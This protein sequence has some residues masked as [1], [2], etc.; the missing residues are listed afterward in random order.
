VRVA[1]AGHREAVIQLPETLRP[2]LG[3]SG[4]ATLFGKEGSAV[5][6][7]LRQLSNAADRQTRTFEARYVLN[8]ELSDAPLGATVSIQIPD[9]HAAT[10]AGWSVPIG[11]LYDA[12]KG[13]GVWLVQ[14]V[15]AKVTW[16]PVK[17]QR[18]ADDSAR[19]EGQLK[20]GDRVVALGAHLL[21][22]GEPVRLAVQPAAIAATSG[23]QP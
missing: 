21:R 15:P 6:A 19:V 22:E 13:P 23:A 14:G 8:G 16:R 7:V 11:A 4:Q 9:G 5:A 20:Q 10:Q 12:G 2:A 1:H 17:V 18:I 3:S